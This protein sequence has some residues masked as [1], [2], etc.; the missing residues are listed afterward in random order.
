MGLNP[1][2]QYSVEEVQDVSAASNCSRLGHPKRTTNRPKRS[3]PNN[4]KFKIKSFASVK[5]QSKSRQR[6]FFNTL[7]EIQ[8]IITQKLLNHLDQIQLEDYADQ[9]AP[10]HRKD[11]L[12]YLDTVTSTDHYIT[13]YGEESLI[14]LIEDYQEE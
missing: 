14:R 10:V 2:F 7:K 1:N 13:H 6:L 12:N 11:L 8:M 4:I 9:H 3:K 5:T